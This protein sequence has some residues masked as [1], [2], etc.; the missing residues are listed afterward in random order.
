MGDDL[1]HTS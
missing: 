1:T